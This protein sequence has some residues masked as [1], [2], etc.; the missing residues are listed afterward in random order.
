MPIQNAIQNRNHILMRLPLIVTNTATVTINGSQEV[1][2]ISIF[3]NPIRSEAIN[4]KLEDIDF[5]SDERIET[6]Q[7]YDMRDVLLQV[8]TGF[9]DKQIQLAPLDLVAGSYVIVVISNEGNKFI[10]KMIKR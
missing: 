5:N 10:G 4:L 9:N 8:Q 2:K 7:I 3:P 6:V 1:K